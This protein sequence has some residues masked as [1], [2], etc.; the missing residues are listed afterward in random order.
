MDMAFKYGQ[1]VQNMKDFGF[2]IWLQDM[3]VLF[4]LTEICIRAIGSM[5][6]HMVRVIITM[7]KEP[8]I[9][10]GGLKINKKVMAE[11]NGPMVVSTK[12]NTSEERNMEKVYFNGQMEPNIM[13]NGKTIKCMVMVN[14]NGQ[15]VVFI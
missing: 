15:M 12:V 8:C 13:E 2:K 5:I 1:M 11:K 3:V 14:L 10:E 9:K 4:L 7:L 6:K